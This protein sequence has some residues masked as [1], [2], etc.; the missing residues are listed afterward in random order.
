MLHQ[1]SSAAPASWC[2]YCTAR[3]ASR[4]RSRG[5][6]LTTRPSSRI[7]P[8][9]SRWMPS[10]VR[11]SV[12]LPQPEF[13][14]QPQHLA[15]PQRQATPAHRPHRQHWRPQPALLPAEQH[16]DVARLEDGLAG[17]HAPILWRSSA[18]RQLTQMARRVGHET[19]GAAAADRGGMRAARREAAAGRRGERRRHRARDAGER[20][21][22]VGMAGEQ[23]ARV[24]MARIGEHFAR[25]ARLDRLPGVHDA[26]S[27]RTA[28]PRRRNRG[29]RTACRCRTPR[30]ATSAA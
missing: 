19:G 7:S 22:A 25:R 20:V 29:S 18:R 4:A 26:R 15:G 12:V 16:D 5:R 3:L 8:P 23:R 11:P 27:R 14:D 17:A 21:G 1:G 10:R 9:V 24:G 30:S 6:P 28:R 13:A 2:T